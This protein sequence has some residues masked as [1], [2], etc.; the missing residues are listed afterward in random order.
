MYATELKLQ[1]YKLCR[2][3]AMMAFPRAF[4]ETIPKKQSSNN[5]FSLSL[6]CQLLFLKANHQKFSHDFQ[7]NIMMLIGDVRSC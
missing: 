6:F 5:G 3:V 1:S 4:L 7:D 2:S